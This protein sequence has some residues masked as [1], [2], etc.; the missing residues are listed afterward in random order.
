MND[1]QRAMIWT[2]TRAVTGIEAN[3][4]ESVQNRK[5]NHKKGEAESKNGELTHML[6]LTRLPLTCILCT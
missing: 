2:R 5:Q 3:G 4:K 1:K 6:N